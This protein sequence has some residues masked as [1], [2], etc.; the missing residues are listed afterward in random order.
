MNQLKTKLGANF[1]AL[2][3]DKAFILYI[4]LFLSQYLGAEEFGKWAL[5]YQAM[6]L[7]FTFSIGP[8]LSIYSRSYSKEF[9]N[10]YFVIFN[11]KIIAL[12]L[13][14]SFVVYGII[15]SQYFL[16]EILSILTFGLY[17]YSSLSLRFKEKDLIYMHRSTISLF[18]FIIST[19]LWIFFNSN[20]TY[21]EILI[22]FFISNSFVIFPFLLQIKFTDKISSSSEH[23]NLTLW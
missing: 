20:I 5:F 17:Q 8:Q 12:L 16:L 3:M 9:Y 11:K 22:F 15:Y 23:L 14:I 10:E 4:S 18:L 1:V 13:L 19:V 6:L 2:G 7:I 21:F